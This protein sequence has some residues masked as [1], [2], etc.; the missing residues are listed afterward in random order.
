MPLPLPN[1]DEKKQDFLSRCMGNPTMNREYPK[2]E[3]RF[4]V[5]QAQYEKK[6]K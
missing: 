4:A 5:C 6:P 1:Q 3:Q 2:R